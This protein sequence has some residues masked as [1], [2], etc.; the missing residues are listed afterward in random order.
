M[1]ISFRSSKRCHGLFLLWFPTSNIL[2]LC[3]LASRHLPVISVHLTIS[4]S[5]ALPLIRRRVALPR[6]D[7][8]S[9]N[10]FGINLLHFVLLGVS[11][12]GSFTQPSDIFES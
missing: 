9:N 5:I 6:L 8:N 4:A 11:L 7:L 3:I 10:V 1:R 12:F 2:I